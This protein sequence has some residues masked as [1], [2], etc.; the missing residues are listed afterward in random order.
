MCFRRRFLNLALLL[1]LL[2]ASSFAL[3]AHFGVGPM[4]VELNAANKTGFVKVNNV[5]NK[6]LQVQVRLF[7]W[8]QNNLAEKVYQESDDLIFFPRLFEIGPGEERLVRI[9]VKL[10]QSEQEKSYVLFIEEMPA[11]QDNEVNTNKP[12]QTQIAVTGRFGVLVFFSPLLPKA[13][14]EITKLEL[15]KGRVSLTVNNP[16]NVHLTIPQIKFD[17]T[18]KFSKTIVGS[19]LLSGAARSY[20]ID[21]PADTCT[22]LDELSVTLKTQ[23]EKIAPVT[24]LRI[25]Q[26]SCH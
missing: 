8:S 21:I 26:A 14:A 18:G 3:A 10:P 19:T 13:N 5:D 1:F 17:Q 9:G 25:D 12:K 22:A 16:G 2:Q 11:S 23:F 4:M 15:N 6:P 20:Y 24:S 7:S